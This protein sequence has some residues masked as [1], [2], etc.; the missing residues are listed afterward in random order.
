MKRKNIFKKIFGY[1]N[2]NDVG[3]IEIIFAFALMLSGFSL[4]SFPLSLGIWI[5]LIAI[6]FLQG[7]NG[8]T[9]FYY[10]LLLFIIYWLFHTLGIMIV[11]KVNIFGIIEHLILFLSIFVIYPTLNLSKLKGSL[12]WVAI[13]AISGLVYQ[14]GIIGSGGMVHQLEI[15]GLSLSAE[16]LERISVRPSSFFQEPAA[17]TAFMMCPLAFSLIDKKYIWTIVMIMSIFLTTSTTGIFVSFIML[18]VSLIN[19]RKLNKKTIFFVGLII[20]SSFFA[21]TRFEAFEY[22]MEKLEDTDYESNV[23]ITQGPYVVGTMEAGEYVFGV[24]YSSAYNYCKSGRAL[25]VSTYG[26]SVYM[27]TFW[28][29][30]L[31]YGVVGLVLYLNVYYRIFKKSRDTWPLIACLCGVLFSSGYG[32]GVFYTYTTIVLLAISNGSKKVSQSLKQT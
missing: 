24:P 1:L 8:K 4:L 30:L 2:L 13:I 17:Y 6:I 15:P 19:H 31:L 23:R 10:P 9:H 12:N 27:S 32:F 29:M 18:F 3:L 26:K 22:G 5:V 21:L 7:K 14:W 20:V 16:T 25:S 11:D 28:M